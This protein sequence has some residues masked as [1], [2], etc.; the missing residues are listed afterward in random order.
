[1]RKP[2]GITLL[3]CGLILV[4]LLAGCAPAMTAT[5]PVP[6]STPVTAPGTPA[7]TVSPPQPTTPPVPESR[8]VELEYPAQMQLGE[9]DVIR[10]TLAPSKAGYIV[11]AEFPD[12]QAA[13]QEVLTQRP[14][15]FELVAVARLDGIAFDLSPQGEQARSLPAGETISWSWSLIA[16][17][18]GRQRLA[19]TLLFRWLAISGSTETKREAVIFSRGLEVQV[20]SILGLAP[21]QAERIG[22]VLLLVLVLGGG[23][24]FLIRRKPGSSRS[25]SP[26]PNLLIELSSGLR[27]TG[28]SNALLRALFSSYSRLLITSEFLSGYSGARTF[29]AQPVRPD[30]RADAYTIVKIGER[31][32]IER[33]YANYEAFVKDTLPP[34]TARIQHAPVRLAHGSQAALRYT[35]IGEAGHAPVSLRQALL[36]SPDPELLHQ[37]VATFGPYWWQQRRPFTFC[38]GTQYDEFLPAHFVLAPEHG[39]AHP[40]DG[41]Y[42]PEE[43]HLEIG[44]RVLLRHFSRVEVRAD[45]KSLSLSGISRPGQPALRV[46]WMSLE[47]PSGAAGRVIATRGSLLAE[48]V[49]GMDLFGLTD[50]LPRLSELLAETIHGTQSIIHGDLNLENVLIGP[51][52]LVWLIDFAR[53]REGH[54]LLDFAHLEAEIISRVLPASIPSPRQYLDQLAGGEIPL[55]T[56]IEA[57]ASQRLFDPGNPREYRLAL[58]IACLG[59]LKH[60]NLEPSGR[61]LLYLTAA[62]LLS[63]LH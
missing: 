11:Q 21:A 24:L 55:L 7:Q 18:P 14:A 44:E 58:A 19:L 22:L 13:Q 49:K 62:F 25:A 31:K 5:A 50:P 43:T 56:Q 38:L 54:T 53:T 45:G 26:N 40:L 20:S 61:H 57:I 27:L 2:W 39:P 59:A 47:K 32:N 48:W 51:R 28:E 12:H 16:R 9:S 46:R 37:M 35:F 30:G 4:I 63:S 10:L 15:G 33:E 23:G 17:Q 29:L 8:Q 1:M 60:S 36:E 3:F 41:S 34:M 6:T 42:S 52:Q